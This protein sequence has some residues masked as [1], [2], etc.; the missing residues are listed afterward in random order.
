VSGF[1]WAAITISLVSICISVRT[2]ILSNRIIKDAEA[3][4][5]QIPTDAEV[6][7]RS[8]FG[9]DRIGSGRDAR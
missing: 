2:I 4:I 5:S 8:I 9:R 7:V 1:Q 3:V 6:L